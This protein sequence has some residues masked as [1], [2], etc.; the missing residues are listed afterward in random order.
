MEQLYEDIRDIRAGLTNLIATCAETKVII[1]QHST[2]LGDLKI[3][4]K[5]ALIPVLFFKW[6]VAIF[7]GIS[8]ISG[9][10]YGVIKGVAYAATLL[11]PP[12]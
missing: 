5:A 11:T 1:C 6:S 3:Q 8:T 7:A 2:D 9:V 4:M 12:Q 10:I